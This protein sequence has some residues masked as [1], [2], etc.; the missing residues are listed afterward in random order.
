M[1]PEAKPE[2]ILQ[3]RVKEI[4]SRPDL[5]AFSQH[6][7]QILRSA[8][9]E[10]ASVRD[11]TA[12]VLREYSVSLKLLRTANSPLYNR[13]G[14]PILSVSHAASLM[15]LQSI[16]DMAAGMMLFEHFRTRSS[17]VRQLMM[18]S[19][20]SANHARET[21]ISLR[22]PKPEEAY[23]CGMFRNLGEVLIA[24]Y[25]A[26]DY[27]QVLEERQGNRLSERLACR[28]VLRFTY[29]DLGRA[30]VEFWGLPDTVRDSM[31][32]FTPGPTRLSP[33]HREMLVSLVSFSHQMTDCVYRSDSG[34]QSRARL[35]EMREGFH[36]SLGISREAL[37]KI[38]DTSIGE[39]KETS[40]VLNIP[41][42]S[43]RLKE[44]IA[45]ATRTE[46]Q[47]PEDLTMF[48]EALRRLQG[49]VDRAEFEL[50]ELLQT[51]LEDVCRAGPFDRALFAF[52]D[53]E[54]N[55]LTGRIGFGRTV[56]ALSRA[57]KFPLSSRGG[58]IAVSVLKKHDVF[59]CG[60]GKGADWPTFQQTLGSRHFVLC[61]I[62]F[63]NTIHG[64]LFCDR[65]NTKNLSE[66]TQQLIAQ[67][68]NTAAAAMKKSQ[69]KL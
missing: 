39:T 31:R 63:D 62:E 68:R 41:L 60:T 30:M 40:R 45:A 34:P 19:L 54:H 35:Q 56:E 69:A 38:L 17:S 25:F 24:C 10:A 3:R 27:A 7:Q 55:L 58:P 22:Y 14:R 65:E 23:L 61:P 49:K 13:S 53:P 44:Q 29:E 32:E 2:E 59:H 50:N 8:G 42:D 64:C 16:R 26:D 46:E 52:V 47:G 37:E 28:K 6:I 33:G 20:L 48:E 12:L 5:P 43:L 15:G 21:A 57:F 18:L 67:Y 9:D 66:G 11:V 51:V 1:P 4:L 36:T